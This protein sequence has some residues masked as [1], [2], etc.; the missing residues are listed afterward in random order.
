MAQQVTIH[1][2]KTNL[3]KL[4]QKALDGEEIIIARGKTPLI[5]LIPLP[6]QRPKRRLGGADELLIHMSNDFDDPLEDFSDY[7]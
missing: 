4:I 3:S 6:E 2:A 1:E 5:Q 7:T